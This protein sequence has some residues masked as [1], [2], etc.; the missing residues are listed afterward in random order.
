M[1]ACGKREKATSRNGLCDWP[2]REQQIPM[3]FQRQRVYQI[4]KHPLASSQIK[5]AAVALSVLSQSLFVN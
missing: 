1:L 3:Y 4:E 5:G 2:E